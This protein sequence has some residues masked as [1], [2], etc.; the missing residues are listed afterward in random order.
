MEGCRGLYGGL[1]ERLYIKVLSLGPGVLCDRLQRPPA[2]PLARA[3]RWLP[4]QPLI[5]LK[6]KIEGSRWWRAI[7]ATAGDKIR[8]VSNC[9]VTKEETAD[10]DAVSLADGDY[11]NLDY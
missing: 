8:R 2:L 3:A 4:H 10:F 1:Y 11:S 9:W 7:Y 6:S 5:K